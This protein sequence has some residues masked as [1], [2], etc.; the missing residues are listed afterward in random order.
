LIDSGS[1]LSR[2]W[3]REH[4]EHV[5]AR[6]MERVRVDFTPGTWE[7]FVRQALGGQSARE[8]AAA[9]GITWN[10]ALMA[11][12]RVLAKVRTELAGFVG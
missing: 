2:L 9:L 1:P 8:V 11:K 10:A 6:V 4:D 3:D 12:S 5:A 7:A